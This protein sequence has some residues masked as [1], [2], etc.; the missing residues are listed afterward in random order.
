M[1][2]LPVWAI[3][4]TPAGAFVLAPVLSFSLAVAAVTIFGLLMEAGVPPAVALAAAGV[5]SRLLVRKRQVRSRNSVA[6]RSALPRR[7]RAER[8]RHDTPYRGASSSAFAAFRSA[9][10]NPSVNRS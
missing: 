7:D 8:G 1:D 6:R 2:S 5:S 9:V 3:W 4:S 10:S